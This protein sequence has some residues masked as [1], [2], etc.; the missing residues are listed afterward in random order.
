MSLITREFV[1]EIGANG[2]AMT[3]GFLP[4][5]RG[6]DSPSALE[7]TEALTLVRIISA[8][9]FGGM[10]DHSATGGR[11]VEGAK[12]EGDIVSIRLD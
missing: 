11:R 4:L 7:K 8:G 9:R 12:W 6:M 3:S 2:L 1:S 5:F 10:S